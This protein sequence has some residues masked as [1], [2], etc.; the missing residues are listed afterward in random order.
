MSGEGTD[1]TLGFQAIKSEGGITFAQD[2]HTAAHANMPRSAVVNGYVDYVL[3]PRQIARMVLA[4]PPG[5]LLHGW[6][7]QRRQAAGSQQS[8]CRR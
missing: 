3:P 7:R 2:E 5:R 4:H 8:G 6:R 1:G